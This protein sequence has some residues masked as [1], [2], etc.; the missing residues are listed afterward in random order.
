M[1]RCPYCNGSGESFKSDE[2]DDRLETCDA[3]QGAGWVPANWYPDPL[4]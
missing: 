3:C 2:D 1:S 4:E